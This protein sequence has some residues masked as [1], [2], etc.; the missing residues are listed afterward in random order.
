MEGLG[1]IYILLFIWGGILIVW[2]IIGA[3]C[4]RNKEPPLK[5]NGICGYAVGFFVA[6]LVL[7]IPAIIHD[8]YPNEIRIEATVVGKRERIK[9][10]ISPD[11]EYYILYKDGTGHITPKHVSMEVYDNTSIGSRVRMI[12]E[13]HSKEEYERYKNW[14]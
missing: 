11:T 13:I 4:N 1:I 6:I 14:E 5:S 12:K 2:L 10:A 9:G 3:I 7:M 8:Y